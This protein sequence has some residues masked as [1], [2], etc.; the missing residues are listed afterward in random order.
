MRSLEVSGAVR[1]LYGSLGV[2]G[3]IPTQKYPAPPL[4]EF[5][6]AFDPQMYR[7]GP[8]GSPFNLRFI[9]LHV[10]LAMIRDE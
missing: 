5:V 9:Y 1:P 2:K 7:R 10:I 3:L 6:F 8:T 4:P